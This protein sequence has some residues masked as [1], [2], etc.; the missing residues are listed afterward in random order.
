[1]KAYILL[2]ASNN[3]KFHENKKYPLM[4]VSKGSGTLLSFLFVLVCILAFW[5]SSMQWTSID[6]LKQF[7]RRPWV[8]PSEK[9][10]SSPPPFLTRWISKELVKK[11]YSL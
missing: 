6:F 5:Y 4:D 8:D 2:Q 3:D 10:D 9:G 7:L 11:V 1:M